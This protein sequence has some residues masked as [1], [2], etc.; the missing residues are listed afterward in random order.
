M[1]A[2]PHRLT[3]WLAPPPLP[4][5][6][7][8]QASTWPS[9]LYVVGDIHGCID[10]LLELEQAIVADAS[11]VK[12]ERWIVCVGD[13]IDRGPASSDVVS[14]LMRPP[15]SGF[16][17][18]ALKGN[19]EELFLAFLQAPETAVEWLE[20][21]GA[22]TAVSYGVRSSLIDRSIPRKL[23]NALR[24]VVPKEHIAWLE[25]LPVSL[26]L[27]GLA[28]V[29]A[30]LRPGVPFDDQSDS[31]LLWIRSPFLEADRDDGLLVVHGHTPTTDPEV[32]SGRICVDTGAFATGILTAVRLA[33][34][35]KPRFLQARR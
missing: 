4:V 18:F 1:S 26:R 22:E 30:G 34:D 16:R 20:L 14:Y 13:Y 9:C 31:D 29:H 21:G 11:G 3:R 15:P 27:P 33:R 17:R 19:H 32:T 12:G 28:V 35:E 24:A 7:R 25:H 23:A 6:K 5:G 8:L 2:F 10:L